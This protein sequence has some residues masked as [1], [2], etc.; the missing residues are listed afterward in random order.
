MH[1]FPSARYSITLALSCDRKGRRFGYPDILPLFF[2][3]SALVS[4]STGTLRRTITLVAQSN[5]SLS[6]SKNPFFLDVRLTA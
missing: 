5:V 2:K 3:Y 6:C 1:W 4:Q